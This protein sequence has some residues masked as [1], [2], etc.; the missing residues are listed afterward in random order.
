MGFDLRVMGSAEL[1]VWG[2]GLKTS[3]YLFSLRSFTYHGLL[4]FRPSTIL[5][6]YEYLEFFKALVSNQTVISSTHRLGPSCE[7]PAPPQRCWGS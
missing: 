5:G 1:E 3:G 6:H 7:L 4:I 2:T